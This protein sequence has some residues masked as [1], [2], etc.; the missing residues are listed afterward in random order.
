MCMK[1]QI[2]CSNCNCTLIKCKRF[3]KSFN[4]YDT[5]TN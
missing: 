4:D 5:I 1:Q 2:A 3:F